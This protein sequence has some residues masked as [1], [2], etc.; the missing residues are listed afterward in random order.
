MATFTLAM[1]GA[2]GAPYALRLLHVLVGAGHNI[3]LLMSHAATRVLVE[4][5]GIE[6]DLRTLNPQTLLAL[7]E[8]PLPCSA[9]NS[10][11]VQYHS[12]TDFSAPVAS[13]SARSDGMVICPCSMGTLAAVAQGISTNLIHRAADV[14]LKERRK[15]I[16][17]PRETP[18]STIHLENMLRLTQAGG[19]VLPAMPG[20]YHKPQSVDDLIDFVVAR[21]CDHLGVELAFSKRW[22]TLPPECD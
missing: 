8:R 5:A 6:I 14:Q 9:V 20:Y 12:L 3:H 16:V 13:G 10:G 2:S 15:L 17:V 22:G 18:L 7:N 4:E 11:R 1:T 19:I 21:I